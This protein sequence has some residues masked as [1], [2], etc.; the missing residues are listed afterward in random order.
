MCVTYLFILGSLIFFIIAYENNVLKIFS[1]TKSEKVEMCNISII[2]KL[3]KH[4]SVSQP[5]I[6]TSLAEKMAQFQHF[7][8]IILSAVRI[9]SLNNCKLILYYRI[10]N[11]FLHCAVHA[12][13]SKFSSHTG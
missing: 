6:K 4:K 12:P 7:L 5:R 9:L 8:D 10:K 13:F 1:L 11:I 2:S 3:T